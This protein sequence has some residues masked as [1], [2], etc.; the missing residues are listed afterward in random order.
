MPDSLKRSFSDFEFLIMTT[1]RV[2][3]NLSLWANMIKPGP[4]SPHQ[5]WPFLRNF[6]RL[7]ASYS[8]CLK[9]DLPFKAFVKGTWLLQ[10]KFLCIN[11][12]LLLISVLR[13]MNCFA[14]YIYIGT[15][16]IHFTKLQQQIFSP[17][18]IF[19]GSLHQL[20]NSFTLKC[21]VSL[22]EEGDIRQV[23]NCTTY[24]CYYKILVK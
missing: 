12:F 22:R 2:D 10:C 23:K 20:S 18:L 15:C 13:D 11:I 17:V 7:K 3:A 8:M 1:S 24:G 4:K 21:M 19:L 5:T 9:I 14:F 16:V 6:H